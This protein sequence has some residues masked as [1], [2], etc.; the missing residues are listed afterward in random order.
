MPE[1]YGT[2]ALTG[3]GSLVLTDTNGNVMHN[4]TPDSAGSRAVPQWT[5]REPNNVGTGGAQSPTTELQLWSFFPLHQCGQWVPRTPKTQPT[6]GVF[7][8]RNDE[9]SAVTH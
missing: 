2:T 4:G 9:A 3:A 7:P 5:L 8:H 6:D 1:L